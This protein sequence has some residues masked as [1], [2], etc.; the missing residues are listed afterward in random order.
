MVRSNRVRLVLRVSGYLLCAVL[1]VGYFLW[2][3]QAQERMIAQLGTQDRRAV[4]ESTFAGFQKFCT[5][6]GDAAFGQ[7][8]ATQGDFLML[9][10]E[11][12]RPCAELIK[13]SRPGPSR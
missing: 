1:F 12:D 7:Y 11:C 8:C 6:Q 3:Q 9:F 2:K 4:F 10:P 5:S 13:R